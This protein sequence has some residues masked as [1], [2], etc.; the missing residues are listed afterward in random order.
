[1]RPADELLRFWGEM[2]DKAASRSDA[3]W[4]RRVWHLEGEPTLLRR[5]GTQ[6]ESRD[7]ALGCHN[8]LRAQAPSLHAHLLVT[9]RLGLSVPYTATPRFTPRE[10]KFRT[11]S[12]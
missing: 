10:P 7:G 5:G 6:G 3:C 9:T 8:C 1:M 4:S 12:R 2:L 11:V